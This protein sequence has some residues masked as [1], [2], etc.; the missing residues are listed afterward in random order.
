MSEPRVLRLADES[1][2][3]EAAAR[4]ARA[5][6]TLDG[7]AVVYLSG[8]LGA[9]KTTFARGLLR[10]LGVEGSIRS[11]SYTLVEEHSAAGWEVLHL[12]LY[13]LDGPDSLEELGLR[14]RHRP[15][16]LLLIEWPEK[17]AGRGLPPPDLE[18][19]LRLEPGEHVAS[20][21]SHSPA[22]GAL[23]HAL[24]GAAPDETGLSP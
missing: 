8:E 20:A 5:L 2:T 23:L 22:G 12:D 17:A 3:F 19:Q 18:L 14:E 10:A 4:M 16:T 13:R 24:L 15:G 1:R 11:P 7:P 9:G 21:I 6:V